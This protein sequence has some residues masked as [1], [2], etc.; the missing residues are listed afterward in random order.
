MDSAK[1][2]HA[3]ALLQE[4]EDTAMVR[5]TLLRYLPLLSADNSLMSAYL[6]LGFCPETSDF[7]RSPD[8]ET[9]QGTIREEYEVRK[10][11]AFSSP[12][13]SD[14]ALRQSFLHTYSDLGL[15]PL[16]PL[17]EFEPGPEYYLTDLW[18]CST[19]P[20]RPDPTRVPRTTSTR[21]TPI[22]WN[23]E[24]KEESEEA[25]LGVRGLKRLASLVKS[26]LSARPAMLHKEV[27]TRIV[28]EVAKTTG[29]IKDKEEKNIKRRLYD[30][31]NVLMAAGAI[32]KQGRTLVW[33]GGCDL[34]PTKRRRRVEEST[35]MVEK[36]AVLRDLGM[37]YLR[38]KLLMQRN[39]AGGWNAD[40]PFPLLLAP[41][42]DRADN[43]VG[44][45]QISVQSNEAGTKMKVSFA[46]PTNWLGDLDILAHLAM[47]HPSAASIEALLPPGF[48]LAVLPK[49]Y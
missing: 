35:E 41:T 24:N 26:V 45:R 27:V 44:T 16:H 18:G 17:P 31:I 25:G 4:L 37:R 1:P 5:V 2:P 36:E 22:A 34:Q 47:G 23:S 30:A 28:E 3:E 15:S 14:Q 40:L 33:Q 48:P 8:R 20:T 19:P 12:R 21:A 13:S 38:L 42:P 10:G 7:A 29:L 6:R 49:Y 32:T 46:H 11:S 9:A 39:A 43:S